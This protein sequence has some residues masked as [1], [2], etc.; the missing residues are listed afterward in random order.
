MVIISLHLGIKLFCKP[1]K[2]RFQSTVPN[3]IPVKETERRKTYAV[4]MPRLKAKKRNIFLG[5]Y[6]LLIGFQKT[7]FSVSTQQFINNRV[8]YINMHGQIVRVRGITKN[9][10]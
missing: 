6:A 3:R 2:K 9:I 8:D 5:A 4:C 1:F 7:V 10:P